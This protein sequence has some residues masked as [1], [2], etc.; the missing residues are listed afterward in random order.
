MPS[1]EPGIRNDR[2]AVRD[3]DFLRKSGDFESNENQVGQLEG[4]RVAF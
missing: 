3:A 1:S 2:A 4:H